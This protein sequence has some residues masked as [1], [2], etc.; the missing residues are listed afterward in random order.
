MQKSYDDSSADDLTFSGEASGCLFLDDDDEDCVYDAGL[1]SSQKD[2]APAATPDDDPPANVIPAAT[3]KRRTGRRRPSKKPLSS[4]TSS[5]PRRNNA[6]RDGR[7]RI[8]LVTK[9]VVGGKK[10]AGRRR[11]RKS[12]IAPLSTSDG[13]GGAG[14]R[15]S[16]VTVTTIPSFLTHPIGERDWLSLC[17][18]SRPVIR[19]AAVRA[20]VACLTAAKNKT[21]SAEA[22]PSIRLPFEVVLST[23]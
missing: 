14:R 2:Y 19:R 21:G 22:T 5:A 9:F 16:P 3:E 11:Q 4:T 23:W 10:A 8:P 13:G 12:T 1:G 18:S 17:P 20:L 15:L 6:S 7:I